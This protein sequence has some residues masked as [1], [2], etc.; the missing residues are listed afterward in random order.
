MSL[1]SKTIVLLGLMADGAFHSGEVLGE[2]LGV[3]RAAVW[4]MLDG[5]SGLGLDVQR[6]R[7]KGYR[8]CGGIDFLDDAEILSF[9]PASVNELFCELLILPEAVSTNQ[10]LLD[11]IN[12]G[13]NFDQVRVCLAE[14]QTAGRGR[15]GRKW[16]S[17][18]ARNIYLS[19]S[20]CFENGIAGME[21]LSLAVGLGVV[22]SLKA[23]GVVEVGLK[24]PNDIICGEA[25]LG[26]V[27]IEIAGDVGGRC[28]AVIGVGVNVRMSEE[29][30]KDVDQPWIDLDGL[31]KSVPSRSQIAASLLD[32]LLPI[33]GDYESK[34]FAHYRL[35]WQEL[36]QH[37]GQTV[38]LETSSAKTKGKM[39]GVDDSGS[40]CLE[41][42]G[43][44]QTFIGGEVSLRLDG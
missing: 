40:L 3:S 10:V 2:A 20:C 11:R 26:G 34:G 6:V 1:N 13:E 28:Q 12:S 38:Q 39:L 25:K 17:P 23:L 15:R 31:L 14:M 16:Q 36:C 27:L 42:A 33:V 24:W 44:E 41:V 22:K 19:F 4:K 35:E 43:V 21:G 5:F 30:M 8:I 18:F 9:L 37:I 32:S 7:G 29:S